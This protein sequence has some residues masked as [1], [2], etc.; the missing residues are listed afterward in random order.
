M[1]FDTLQGHVELVDGKLTD[2]YTVVQHPALSWK[3]IREIVGEE[4]IAVRQFV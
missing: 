4:M 1:L 3:L 2:S